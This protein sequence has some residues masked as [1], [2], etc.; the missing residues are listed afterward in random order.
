MG[1]VDLELENDGTLLTLVVRD[2]GCG[3]PEGFDIDST[4][5]LGLSIVREM[6]TSQ[7]EGSIVMENDGG[8]RVT[9]E[10]PVPAGPEESVFG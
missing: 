6:V 2:D 3:L 9:I 8:T 10:V 4:P 7:L 5:S 1:H